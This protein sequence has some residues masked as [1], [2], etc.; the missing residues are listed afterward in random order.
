MFHT[1]TLVSRI[2]RQARGR[3]LMRG[4]TFSYDTLIIASGSRPAVHYDGP[5]P[6][7][8]VFTLRSRKDADEILAAA[9]G[10]R[11]G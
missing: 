4:R 11:A 1:N 8:G 3:F 2:D 5:I 9:E 6:D 10:K 7:K